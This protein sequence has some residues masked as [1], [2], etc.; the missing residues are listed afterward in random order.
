MSRKLDFIPPVPGYGWVREQMREDLRYRLGDRTRRTSLGRPLYERINVQIVMTQ[1]CPYACPFCLERKHPMKGQFDPDAQVASLLRVLEEHP[2]ARLTITGGEPGLYP[3]HVRRLAKT[4]RRNSDGVF[5]SVNTAGYDPE[6][7]EIPGVHVNLSWNRHVQPDPALFPGCTVQTVLPDRF[8]NIDNFR[9]F[10]REHPQAGSFS[11]RYL[12]DTDRP[13]D[14]DVSVLEELRDSPD[15]RVGTFRVGD[16]FMYC[17]FDLDG[18][19]CRVTIGDMWQ[20]TRN[21]YG[22]GYSNVIIHPDGR[23]GVNWN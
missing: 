8:M 10:M 21:D 20:Q 4:Y 9:A 18:R 15:V 23:V 3:D 7:G 5:C 14:Y 22:D 2:Q 12:S 17:T 13:H 16:F 19:H 6:L 11:F 1:E